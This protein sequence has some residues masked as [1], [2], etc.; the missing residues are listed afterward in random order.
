MLSTRDGSKDGDSDNLCFLQNSVYRKT[1][2]LQACRV[3]VA[4]LS[5]R[6][7]VAAGLEDQ[8]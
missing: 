4:M 5:F 1:P 2:V 8:G 3:E 7:N 6:K